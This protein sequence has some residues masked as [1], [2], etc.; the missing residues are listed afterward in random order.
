MATATMARPRISLADPPRPVFVRW[1]DAWAGEGPPKP[2]EQ[3][4]E[5]TLGWLLER[6]AER[7]V[8]AQTVDDYGPPRDV[9]TIPRSLV[10]SVLCTCAKCLSRFAK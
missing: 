3:C 1:I 2:G 5:R 9:L 10:R 6:S 7:V 4:V 8:I